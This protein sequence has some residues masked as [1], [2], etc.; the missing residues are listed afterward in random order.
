MDS[1]GATNTIE[2]AAQRTVRVLLRQMV[3]NDPV[4]FDDDDD[5][6][7]DEFETTAAALPDSNS[8]TWNNG[9]VH[10]WAIRGRTDPLMPDTDGDGLPDGLELGWGSPLAATDPLA[11]TNGDGW[12]NF[13][14]DGDVPIYNTTDNWQHPRYN[15]N[16]SRSR[17]KGTGAGN[18]EKK[19]L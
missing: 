6:L 3:A 18:E 14:G 5:G 15:F 4:D 12:P 10:M 1:D 7:Y 2:G 8:E 9:D 13:I 19:R 16:A 11:D 17:Y